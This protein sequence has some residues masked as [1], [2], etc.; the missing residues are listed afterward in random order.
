MHS[1]GNRCKLASF[2][3]EPHGFFNYGRGDGSNYV[4]TTRI[5]DEFLAELGY[6]KG[7]P[8]VGER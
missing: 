2:K 3:D 7:K 5:M 1:A 6:V 8:T 4:K